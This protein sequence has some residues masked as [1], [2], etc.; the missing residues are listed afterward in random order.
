MKPENTE[1]KYFRRTKNLPVILK[2]VSK[3]ELAVFCHNF[4]I[5]DL[6]F[7]FLICTV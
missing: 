2:E 5:K 1:L 6:T 7:L 4:I 3:T